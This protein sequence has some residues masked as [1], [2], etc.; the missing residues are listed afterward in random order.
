[1]KANRIESIINSL[2]LAAGCTIGG[3]SVFGQQSE[4]SYPVPLQVRVES[5]RWYAEPIAQTPVR[6]PERYRNGVPERPPEK[7]PYRFVYEIRMRNLTH[8][9]ILSVTLKYDLF[10]RLSGELMSSR[11]FTSDERI[12]AYGRKTVLCVSRVPPTHVIDT[13]LLLLNNQQ[14]YKESV[15]ITSITF[16]EYKKGRS[17]RKKT[18]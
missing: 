2:V 12:K 5:F 16:R 4:I 18:N 1:M 9:D 14:P 15:S 13:A 11:E 8:K 6:I 17:V 10:D 3:L 7:D